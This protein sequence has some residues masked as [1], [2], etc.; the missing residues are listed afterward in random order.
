MEPGAGAIETAEFSAALSACGPFE[1]NPHIAVAVSGGADSMALLHLLAEWAGQNNARL[2][3]LTVDHNLRPESAEEAR[4]VAAWAAALDIEHQT[5][6]WHPEPG[7]PVTQNTARQA[8]YHLLQ[9]ECERRG[10]RHLAVAHHQNDQAETFLLRL[11][12]GS[13]LDGLACMWS[14]SER[15][16]LTLLRP[17]LDFPAARLQATCRARGQE[18]CEDPSNQSQKYA[19]PRLRKMQEMLK[20][21]GFSAQSLSLTIKRLQGAAAFIQA[22]T[23]KLLAAAYTIYPPDRA[24]LNLSK[25]SAAHSEL[26]QRSLAQLIRTIGDEP[27]LPRAEQMDDLLRRLARPDFKRATLGNCLLTRKGDSL[28]IEREARR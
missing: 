8:R 20:N 17:L 28:L 4:R 7:E 2:L 5:L 12:K 15:G 1:P 24:E 25:W 19:R 27:Y 6:S 22:E 26:Q 11:A 21:E 14:V 9:A 10:I 16:T 18:W 23:T 3:A 13:G